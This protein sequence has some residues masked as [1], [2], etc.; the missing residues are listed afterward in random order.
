MLPDAAAAVALQAKL[1]Y[2]GKL[3]QQQVQIDTLTGRLINRERAC[4]RRENKD[5]EKFESFK[6]DSSVLT[7]ELRGKLAASQAQGIKK[8][9]ECKVRRGN[10]TA[11]QLKSAT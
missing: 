9:E 11:N 5:H 1:R 7:E 8:D 10:S 2:N 6:T 3:L 4:Q